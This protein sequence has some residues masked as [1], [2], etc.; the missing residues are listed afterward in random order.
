M[1]ENLKDDSLKCLT[2][3]CSRLASDPIQ[4]IGWRVCIREANAFLDPNHPFE[5]ALDAEAPHATQTR[6]HFGHIHFI[7]SVPVIMHHNNR[8]R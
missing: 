3:D 7:T 5:M 1:V 6:A 4:P 8:T 2:V